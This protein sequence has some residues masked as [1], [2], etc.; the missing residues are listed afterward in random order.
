MY[1][2]SRAGATPPSTGGAR[3][4]RF[5]PMLADLTDIHALPGDLTVP[6]VVD[7]GPAPGLRVRQILPT[8]SLTDLYGVLYLPRAWQPETRYPLVVE[9][10]G[11]GPYEDDFGDRCTGRH[12][13]AGLGAG[14]AEHLG[15]LWLCQ[16]FVSTDHLRHQEMWWGD[17]DA[18]ADYA[19][20]AVRYVCDRWGADAD[21]VLLCGF[22]R[23]AIACNYIGLR[24]DRI[25][26]LWRAFFCHSHY[27]GVRRW[28]H[29]DDD[30]ASARRRLQRLAGRPQFVSHEGSVEPT[31]TF[32][33]TCDIDAPITFL[34]LPYRNHSDA[35]V[36][37]DV[38][39]RRALREWATAALS[40]R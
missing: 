5:G 20:A 32:L 11:N 14:L 16:P 39:E 37:R 1:I 29:D 31:R 35:W 18:T 30:E 6:P 4:S 36:L 26:R 2:P 38:P 28:G 21:R 19:V 12:E 15:A 7:G 13:D 10:P 17:A 25:A 22:S 24:S 3:Q 40:S 34:D 27:D 33:S 9:Y 23:G 8:W